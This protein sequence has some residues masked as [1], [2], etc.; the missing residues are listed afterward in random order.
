MENRDRAPSNRRDGNRSQDEIVRFPW[1]KDP[2]NETGVVGP[3]TQSKPGEYILQC[4]F[5]EFCRICERK[6]EQVLAEPLERPLTKSLQRGEDAQFDQILNSLGCAAEHCLPSILRTLFAW[7]DRQTRYGYEDS[8]LLDSRQRHRSKGSKDVLCER[9]DLAVEF[10]HCLILVEVLS[11]LSYHP[12][13]DDLVQHIIDQ[14]FRHF[15]Y[16]DG[17][18]TNP[19]AANINVI[20]DLYAEVIGVLAA[21]RFSAV[22]KKFMGELRELKLRDQTP[23][24][25]Q[26]IISLLMGLKFFRVKMHPIEDFEACVHFLLEMGHYF[27]EVKDRDIK[28]ALAGLFVEI[29]LPVAATVKNEVNIPVLKKLVDDLYSVTVDMTT[30][31]KHTLHLFPLVTCLLCVSQKQFFLSNW[32]YFLT[33]CLSQLKNKDP[34]M[35]RIA[36]ESLYRLLWVYMVRIKC[37]SNTATQSRLQSIVNSLFPKGSKM[38][39]PKDTPLNIFVKI[40]QFIAKERLDFAVRDIIF[41]L[42]CVGRSNKLFLTP[43]RMSIGLRA[44]LVIADSLEQKD[45]DPPMPQSNAALPSGSTVRH[46]RT[47]LNKMLSDS[48]ARTIGLAQYYSHILKTFDSILRALDLQVGRPLLMTKSENANKEPDEMITGDRKPK[49]D[50]FRTCIAAIPRLKPD[51]MTSPELVDL[52]TR[53]TVHVD[54]ELKGLA[55]QALQNLMS[56]SQA[57]KEHVIHGFVQFIMKDISD[58]KTHLLDMTLRL[59]MQ[60]LVQWKT[61]IGT[62]T[63]GA[64]SSH[65]KESGKERG[66][67]SCLGSGPE[68]A[69]SVDV[70]HE[71]EGLCL[72]MMCS[73]RI[74]TRKLAFHLLREVRN[75]LT[76]CSVI[77]DFSL[78]LLDV[79]DK[80]CPVIVEKLLSHL[81]PQEKAIVLTQPNIDLMWVADRAVTLWLP[82]GGGSLQEGNQINYSFHRVDMWIRFMAAVVSKDFAQISCQRAIAHAWPIVYTRLNALF[83]SIDP[84]TQ[85]NEN[86]ASS[87]LRSGSKK[88]TTEK[89]VHMQLWQNYIILACSIAQQS[90][91]IPQRCSSPELGSLSPESSPSDKTESRSSCTATNLFR[92]LVPLM[93]CENSDMRDTVVNGLGYCNPAVF[94]EL[95]EEL[96]PFL[97]EA[98]DKKQDNLRRRRKRDVL[99]VQLAHIFQLLAENRVFAQSEAGAIDT[100]SGQLSSMFV[101]YIDGARQYLEGE[102]DRDLP[103]L[104]EIRLHFSCF[105]QHLI[106]NTPM[107]YRKTLLSRDLRYSLFHLFANWSGHFGAIDRRFS[108]DETWSEQELPAVRAMSAVL[109]CGPVFDV[110]GFND[111]GYIYHWLDTLLSSND[112]KIYELAKETVYLLLDFNPDAQGLL[113]WV[114]DRCYTGQK[115]VAD[116]CF[117]A[118]AA[119]F[120]NK[121]YPCDHVAML[122]LAV[123]NVGSPRMSIHETALQLLHLLDARFLQEEVVFTAAADDL[124][125]PPQLPLNDVLLAVSYYHSQMCLSQQ[126][127]RLHPDLTMPMFSEITHRFQTARP[128]VRQSLLKYLL[129]WLHNMELVDPSLP[130]TNPLT[131]FLT[132]L[133]DSQQADHFLPP[134]KG[135]GWGSTQATEMVLNNLFYITV[136]FGDEHPLEIETLWA[137]LVMCWPSNLKVLIRYLL[138][139]INMAATD[140]LPFAKRVVTYLG[141]AKPEKLVDEIMNELQ[142]VETLNM[143][144]ER[145]QTPPFY[146]L[147]QLRK[148]PAANNTTDDEKLVNHEPDVQLQKGVLHTKRHSANEDIQNETRTS[149]TNST[150]SLKSITSSSTGSTAEQAMDDEVVAHTQTRLERG[151]RSTIEARRSESPVPHPLPMPAYGGYFAPLNEMLPEDVPAMQGFH[152]SNIAVML[153][154]DLVLDGLEVDWSPHLPLMLHIIF[155]GLDHSRGLVYE[156]CKKLLQN[157]LLL[158]SSNDHLTCARL[159]L[160]YRSNAADTLKVMSE[161]RDA[162]SSLDIPSVEPQ[163]QYITKSTFSIDSSAT[164]TAETSNEL[165]DVDSFGSVDEI[166]KA[167]LSFMDTRKGKP[168]WSSE[169]ITPKV[170]TT[171][172]STHLQSF[173]KCVVRCFKE[174]SPMALVEQRWSQV[175]LQLALSCSSRHY[176]GR[177]F[178]VLRALQIRPTTQMLSDI[179]SRL[180]ETVAEQGE[181]MQGYVTEIMLTLEAFV[182][183]LDLELRP[184]DFMRELFMSTP[185]LAKDQLEN[186]HSAIMAPKQP[187]PHHARSTSYSVSVF[188]Q[189]AHYGA[190]GKKRP[191][192]QNVTKS[193]VTFIDEENTVFVQGDNRNRSSTDVEGHRSNLGRSRSAQSLKNLDQSGMEDK[194]TLVTQIF[195]IT[196]SLLESDYEYEFSLAVRLLSKILQHLQPERPDCREKLDKILQQIKWP[197]FP[198][199]FVL[200]LKGCTSQVAAEA[201]WALL[202]K[203]I[204][205]INSPVMDPSGACGFALVTTAL[206]P[207]LVHNYENPCQTCRDAADNIAQMCS[208]QSEDLTNLATVMSLYSRGTFG[209][210]S[211]QWTKCVIKYLLD[212]YSCL[213]LTLISFLVEVLEKG[214]LLYQPDIL[215]ILYCI[216][217]YV[218][219]HALPSCSNRIINQELFHTL[220]K[221]LQGVHWKEA[222]KILKLAIT[223]SSTLAA[224]P[225]SSSSS[226]GTSELSSIFLHTPFAENEGI[227][228]MHKELPGRTLDFTLEVSRMPI[229]GLKFLNSDTAR[230]LLAEEKMPAAI[231][232]GVSLSRKPSNNQDIDSVW[233]RPQA[234]QS[235]TRERLVNLLTCFGQRVGLPKSPSDTTINKVIFSQ[236]SDTLDHQ[237]S[238]GGSSGEEA[239]IPDA[240]SNDTLMN[241]SSGNELIVTFKGFD[242]LDNELEE[243]ENE[244]FFSQ[245]VDRRT[246]LPLDESPPP[247]AKRRHFGSVPDLKMIGSPTLMENPLTPADSLSNKE[248]SSDDESQSSAEDSHDVP[249]DLAASSAIVVQNPALER[250]RSSPLTASTHSLYSNPSEPE[251]CELN[252]S[253]SGHGLAGH[254]WALTLCLQ[255]DEVEEV[256]RAHVAKVMAEASVQHAIHTCQVFPRLYREMR[257]R[258]MGMTKEAYYYISKTESLKAIASQFLQMLEMIHKQMECPFIYLEAD[259]L[260]GGR[261]LERHRFCVLEIQECVETYVLRKDLAEQGL[262]VLK[263]TIKQQSLGDGGTVP[264]LGE[265]Q[266]LE[267]CRKLYKLIFQLILL[268]ESYL[269]LLEVFHTVTTFPQVTDISAQVTGLRQELCGAMAELESGQASP[270]NVDSKVL[271]REDAVASLTEYLTSHQ[272]LQAIHI[273]RSFRSMW[274]NDI[275]GMTSED[276]VVTL[277]NIYCSSMAEKKQGL[278]ALT[279]LD[280]DLGHLYAQLMDINVQITGNAASA[281]VSGTS[282]CSSGSSSL[283]GGSGGGATGMVVSSSRGQLVI[284]TSDSSVL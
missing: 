200:L 79:I 242:F 19:N 260:T 217:H 262:E 111:D 92:L 272:Q 219:I 83:P 192:G 73:C 39:T 51:G 18:Q 248:T 125:R 75:I 95:A 155:L 282:T 284:K 250:R 215:Q 224:P 54:E 9:R 175:A 66:D 25:A 40:I 257:K 140:L 99:R 253:L 232:A 108:K 135:E 183:N 145:T 121:E 174:L 31:R 277:L 41:D 105:V 231:S 138:V 26:S 162:P 80:A 261:V 167:I 96:L 7:H 222:L 270:Y 279:R 141:R 61:S 134:L 161:D 43:E 179:L 267:V 3:D 220:N 34:K 28:H 142:T 236:S 259:T 258:L 254:S 33:M 84:N 151:E 189:R 112:E 171:Q 213:A 240:S 49:I 21:S 35:S 50:L 89:D 160:G 246:S 230:S 233:R 172:S 133:S 14:A 205:C 58:S 187:Y 263:S 11:K 98:I 17:L 173:L 64:G 47:F 102:N 2:G 10:V 60:L 244:D 109:C 29:L 94:K 81:P 169:D 180:V 211:V 48:T 268:F 158:A 1:R 280:V 178:Q 53:L 6:I 193:V 119:V 166:I 150:G 110:N 74:M 170:L 204:L 82:A 195:W 126:L 249:H 206:L 130:A 241:D 225:P 199:V 27:L 239:S 255:G 93:K 70:L 264:L 106:D 159:L 44:F 16:R 123:L 76:A 177:S 147:S 164:I 266:K 63:S 122:N 15:K 229:I 116:G 113:D 37:E 45:G 100:D 278:F 223:R 38:V 8:P 85:L 30:K 227:S 118:L 275:F 97:K 276:D 214:A 129:P 198:G 128:S 157:L 101:D 265:D 156:H 23:Y 72:V 274:Q 91:V 210:D 132:R 271:S 243:S 124:P 103:I 234:S 86:R 207:Y 139:I 137:A 153:L 273:L 68:S 36:L 194:L 165:S 22:R 117:K 176:A 149:R 67:H 208:Q 52:L 163:T 71:V 190:E 55:F 143:N 168:L 218:D 104:Q 196:V 88:V 152:R 202:S 32:P 186:R 62:L 237:Q 42:L 59:L 146:R 136:K 77:Q 185:N 56:E 181:D 209:K 235:R 283:I 20:A 203:T 120:Q 269:K 226:M 184:I 247:P 46:K 281:S 238:V 245:L 57:W 69:A 221:H 251:N 4:L 114:I 154:S 5:L 24:T 197:N 12:G 148:S 65:A 87:I 188:T 144:I 107:E 252:S 256:W 212:V 90:A 13:H 201:T 228:R 182:E 78:S 191:A 216:A 127:A 131:N 115:E